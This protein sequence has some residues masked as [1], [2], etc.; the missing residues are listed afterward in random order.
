[1][2]S[3]PKFCVYFKWK[4]WNADVR[5]QP[6]HATAAGLPDKGSS[7][8]PHAPGQSLIH[9]GSHPGIGLHPPDLGT[10][11]KGPT[12]RPLEYSK[13]LEQNQAPL[14]RSR[15]NA[16]N[17]GSLDDSPVSATTTFILCCNQPLN[18]HSADIAYVHEI[19]WGSVPLTLDGMTVV[20]RP[21]WFASV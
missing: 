3:H 18:N 5:F 13:L 9:S 15:P 11:L 1:M 10:F 12:T 6:T 2:A 8:S 19:I 20:S 4:L 17:K 7:P 14:P 16:G 21:Q